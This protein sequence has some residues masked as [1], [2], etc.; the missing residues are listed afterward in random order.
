MD[1]SKQLEFHNA[2]I[3]HYGVHLATGWSAPGQWVRFNAISKYITHYSHVL[4]YG[5]GTGDFLAHICNKSVSYCGV[6]INPELIQ[7]AKNRYTGFPDIQRRFIVG[8][9]TSLDSSY[10][11]VIASGVFSYRPEYTQ[12]QYKREVKECIGTLW[13]KCR[14]TMV[15]NFLSDRS[16][17]RLE[18]MVRHTLYSAQDVLNIVESLDCESFDILHSIKNNDITLVVSKQ[19]Y[20]QTI[21]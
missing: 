13:S 5:C 2:L 3:K 1:Y 6:D 19:F 18:L 14:N 15:V 16:K 4:D 12:Y 21:P 8:D 11:Y 17:N 9:H 20:E 10:D 7:H